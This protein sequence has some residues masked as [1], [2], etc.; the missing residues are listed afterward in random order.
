MYRPFSHLR[1]ANLAICVAML[2]S[3]LPGMA[4]QADF[5]KVINLP[6]PAAPYPLKVRG[7]DLREALRLFAKNLRI[8]LVMDEKVSAE[9]TG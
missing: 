2:Q 5:A 7:M 4:Q 8:G 1:L 9:I 6:D 3:P